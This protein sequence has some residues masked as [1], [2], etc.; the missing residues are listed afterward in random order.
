MAL[1]ELTS[2]EEALD[3]DE[4]ELE[5]ELEF[6]FELGLEEDEA[7]I[8]TAGLAA[9]VVVGTAIT[10]AVE[11][12]GAAVGGS[13]ETTTI[14]GCCSTELDIVEDSAAA[15]DSSGVASAL[16]VTGASVTTGA[17]ISTNVW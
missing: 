11:G 1:P 13:D 7:A 4:D 10:G 16:E 8:V 3:E 15:V 14:V 2:P 12:A 5:P 9:W 17:G 6:E